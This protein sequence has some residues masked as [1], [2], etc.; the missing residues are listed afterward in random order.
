MK[1]ASF[2]ELVGER[3]QPGGGELMLL[4]FTEQAA[5]LLRKTR[6]TGAAPEQLQFPF[7]PEQQRPQHHDSAFV[8]QLAGRCYRQLFQ[9]KPGQPV[10]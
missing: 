5:E 8:V 10:E 9:R 4:Q 6:P 3:A 2:R 7:V 1:F